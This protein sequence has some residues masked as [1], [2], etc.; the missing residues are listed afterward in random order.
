M[1][2]EP[3]LLVDP[4]TGEQYLDYNHANVIDHNHRIAAIEEVTRQ[5]QYAITE[6]QEGNQTHAWHVEDPEAYEDVYEPQAEESEEEE[7]YSEE[8]IDAFITNEVYEACG[9][10]EGYAE[11]IDFAKEHWTEKDIEAFDNAMDTGNLD[12]MRHAINFLIEDYNEDL[13]ERKQYSYWDR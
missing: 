8:E 2:V 4:S 1:T 10:R 9:G 3:Q 5:Q 13:E 12:L 6:D 7:E 11:L